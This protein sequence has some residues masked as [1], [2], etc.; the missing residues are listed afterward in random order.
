MLGRGQAPRQKG[1][2][3]DQSPKL[4]GLDRGGATE[5]WNSTRG[6]ELGHAPEHTS[7]GRRAHSQ[8]QREDRDKFPWSLATLA[9]WPASPLD[10]NNL[11]EWKSN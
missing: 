9:H 4:R 11:A 3:R 6:L 10:R 1:N 2:R 5:D 8:V 7:Q